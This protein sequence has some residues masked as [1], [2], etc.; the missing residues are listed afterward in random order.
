MAAKY[1]GIAGVPL[2]AEQENAWR[3]IRQLAAPFLAADKL[4]LPFRS[5]IS[6]FPIG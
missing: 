6:A 4:L 3:S 5:G 1:A 2:T